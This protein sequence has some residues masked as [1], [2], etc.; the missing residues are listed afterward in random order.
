MSSSVNGRLADVKETLLVMS[1]KGGV[2]KSTVAVQLAN[3]LVA[4]GKRVGLL[5][6]DLTGPSVPRLVGLTTHAVHKAERGWVPVYTDASQAL[7]VMSIQFLLKGAD[8]PVIWRG[9]KKNAVIRQ[10]LE[11][12][13]W[14]ELDY[15][16][17]DTPPGTSDEHISTCELLLAAAKAPR[18]LLVTTPQAV[19]LSDVRKEAAF[20]RQ[21]ALPIVGI[22]ENMSGYVCTHCR[23]CTNIFSSDGGRLLAEELGVPFAGR[24]PIDPLVAACEDAGKNFFLEHPDSDSLAAIAALADAFCAASAL[25]QSQNTSA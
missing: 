5:D 14:G 11:D 1:G 2:G 19:A 3:A 22:V 13:L 21:L 8:D 25:Q 23:E 4:R 20:C 24:V 6:V 18:A 15:L 7:A 16:V 10:F 12:V 17:V 9:P